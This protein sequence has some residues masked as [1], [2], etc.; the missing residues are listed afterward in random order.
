M[1]MPDRSRSLE[2]LITLLIALP[3][4]ALLVGLV[5]CGGGA[6]AATLSTGTP[7][8]IAFSSY[9]A[10]DGTDA[11]NSN[12]PDGTLPVTN[13]WAIKSDGTGLAAITQLSGAAVGADSRDPQ[14]SPDGSKIVYSSG[15][16]LDGS[17]NPSI[18]GAINV[19]VSN[20][21]GSGAIPLTQMTIYAPCWAP[22]WSPDGTKIAYFSWRGLDGSNANGGTSGTRNIWV[23]NADGSNNRPVTQLTAV[24]ADS[25][26]PRW[27]PD[28][29]KLAY[30]S[31]RALDGSDAANGQYFTQNIWIVK[32]DGS[33][34]V[35]VT[36][37]TGQLG[38]NQ[39]AYWSKDGSTL[40]FAGNGVLT[41]HADG[42]GLTQ[43]T[44]G[45]ASNTPDGW[46]PDGTKILFESTLAPDGSND[47]QG[48]PNIWVMNGDGS[49][50]TPLTK[51]TVPGAG[52]AA[53]S[54]DGTR[55]AYVSDRASNGSDNP[56]ANPS[57]DNLWLMQADGSGSVPLT[58]IT[59]ANSTAP[60]WKP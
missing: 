14:W 32:T 29:T 34:A 13:I 11:V 5:A 45:N 19:W 44:T 15:R 33:G 55:I 8:T 9:R 58:K 1:F 12:Q 41:V 57:V 39:D 30:Y 2:P 7:S 22:V 60:A 49:N 37:L 3:T 31:G 24:G 59:K 40:L 46:S 23:I 50:P 20:P 26:Y 28:S 17:D 54:P 47:P 10:L 36:Q 4:L 16:A 18:G 42:S 56:D 38:G 21:D 27:S 52:P 51:L 25:Y 35:P 48:S 43:L 53:W 6:G